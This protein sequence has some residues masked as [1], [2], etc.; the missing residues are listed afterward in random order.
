M[1]I[2]RLITFL[3]LA[4][5]LL[6]GCAVAN[7]LPAPSS[8]TMIEQL[9]MA[10]AVEFSLEPDNPPITVPLPPGESISLATTGLTSNQQ[11]MVGVISGWLGKQG[12][13]IR[14]ESEPATYRARIILQT[15]GTEQ[16]QSFF[17]MPAVQ[18][19]LLPF[20]LPEL[21][22]F[23]VNY[24]TGYARF[25][26]EFYE[27]ETGRFVR[28]TPWYDGTTYYNHYTLLFFIDFHRTNLI[29]GPT[30]DTP[31]DDKSSEADIEEE[32]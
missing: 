8:P 5:S 27:K 24:Q 17:G 21:P 32:Y 11:F 20:A 13:V 7:I 14:Q 9:L 10:Q 16:A 30:E 31:S 4:C 23:K 25:S 15:L 2:T 18:V 12:F 22:V 1:N 26:L 6:S 29:G 19:A 28:S 3:L